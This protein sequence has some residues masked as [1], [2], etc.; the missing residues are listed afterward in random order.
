MLN[1]FEEALA[2]IAGGRVLDVATQEGGFVRILAKGLKSYTDIVGVDIN[3]QAM[4]TAKRTIDQQPI[5]FAQMDARQMGFHDESLDTVSISASL[6]HLAEIP[7]V[8][9]EMKRVLGRGG[10]FVLAEMHR[11]AQ[12]E[13]QLTM[14]Y[15]HHWV[16]EVDSGHGRLHDSTL[17]RQELA[18]RVDSLE[19]CNVESYDLGAADSGP[20]GQSDIEQLEGLIDKTI[21]R[22]EG[23]PNRRELQ[24]RGQEL[25]QRLQAVGA[26][27]E[28]VLVVTAEKA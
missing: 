14:V 10:H 21:R 17:H 1:A 24:S 11:D 7:P 15:L 26:Q 19:L 23:L 8:L 18:D 12:T 22:A 16:A 5:Q 28:P 6:H 9:A 20:I 2:D 3:G 27:R 4:E 13:A 25:R